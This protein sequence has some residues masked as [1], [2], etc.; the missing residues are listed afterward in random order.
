[1]NPNEV[2]KLIEDECVIRDRNASDRNVLIFGIRGEAGSGKDTMADHLETIYGFKKMSFATAL[3][4]IVVILTGWSYEFVN[5]TNPDLRPLRETLV[6]PFYKMTCRQILQFI[7]TDLLRN[8]LHVDV[9]IESVRNE[10]AEYVKVCIAEGRDARIVFTDARFPNE[11]DMIQG[12][13]GKMFKILRPGMNCL[14]GNTKKHISEADFP[15]KDEVTIVNDGSLKEFIRKIENTS[16][17]LVTRR[18]VAPAA[19]SLELEANFQA[20]MIAKYSLLGLFVFALF[21]V[22]HR[23]G[24][25][26]GQDGL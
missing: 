21:I 7:G 22:L 19:T 4:R 17:E 14:A 2:I 18:C 1:M 16:L 23:I 25:Y 20:A 5:G 13:G 10:I 24:Q 11:V 26:L 8:Q 9:W 6:H 3:K 15:V 12:L